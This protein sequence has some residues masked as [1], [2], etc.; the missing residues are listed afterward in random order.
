MIL[1]QQ[2]L[3]GTQWSDVTVVEEAVSNTLVTVEVEEAVAETS[4]RPQRNRVL[5]IRLHDYEVVG[6]MKSHQMEN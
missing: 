5:P 2:R 6:M 4:Q 1:K 3:R